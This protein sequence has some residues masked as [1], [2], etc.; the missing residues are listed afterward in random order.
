MAKGRTVSAKELTDQDVTVIET[1]SHLSKILKSC[2][3][4]TD[5]QKVFQEKFGKTNLSR[6]AGA[7]RGAG[8]LQRDALCTRGTTANLP[9]SNRN[10]RWH[11]LV[12]MAQEH[13]HIKSV[14]RLE[15]DKDKRMIN[16]IIRDKKKKLIK[17]LSTLLK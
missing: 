15:I 3:K 6:D 5:G 10:L 9:I 17:I 13:P 4:S 16:F 8:K 2:I 7:G 12:A 14:E 1:C 11:P